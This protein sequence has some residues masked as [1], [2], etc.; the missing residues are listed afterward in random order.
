MKLKL[1]EKRIKLERKLGTTWRLVMKPVIS[2]YAV[3]RLYKRYEKKKAKITKEQGISW[4]AEDIAKY[5]IRSN[6]KTFKFL[7]AEYV[8]SDLYPRH[9]C[10]GRLYTYPF[11]RRS[12][13]KTAYFKFRTH[14]DFQEK[15]M[16]SVRQYPQF[17]VE[18]TFE[19]YEKWTEA[20]NYRGTYTVCKVN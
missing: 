7:L 19:E 4:V 15:V 20:V 5:M 6:E 13:A 9:Y 18:K 3:V 17:V 8:D 14:V 10:L 16:E 2:H 11:I 12:K 1:Y